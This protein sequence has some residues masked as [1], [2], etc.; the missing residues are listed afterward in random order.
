[1]QYANRWPS[2]ATLLLAFGTAAP[3][4]AEG[5]AISWHKNIDEAWRFTQTT[6]QPLLLFIQSDGCTYCHQMERNT[7]QD[8]AVATDVRTLFVAASIRAQDHAELVQ[9]LQVHAYPTTFIISP[10]A[11]VLDAITGYLS[12]EDMRGRLAAAVRR[13]RPPER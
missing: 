8:R 9:R 1:M 13:L 12:P 7:F 3:L 5:P 2:L 6:G 11:Q 4:A 10:Q